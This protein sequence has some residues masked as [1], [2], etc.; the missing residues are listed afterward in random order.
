MTRHLPRFARHAI[1]VVA[2]ILGA[3]SGNGV[4]T[5]RKLTPFHRSK[6]DPP[7]RA[8]DRTG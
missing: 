3:C 5:A 1:V 6:T 7:S 8:T 2:A 4:N